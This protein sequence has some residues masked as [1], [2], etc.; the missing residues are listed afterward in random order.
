MTRFTGWTILLLFV[1]AAEFSCYGQS[2][3]SMIQDTLGSHDLQIGLSKYRSKKYEVALSYFTKAADKN[4]SNWRA[5]RA[6][7]NAERKVK[8]YERAIESYSRA[9]SINKQDTSSFKGRAEAKRMAG[10]YSE[11]LEDY[12][13]ALQWD[14]ND[15][16]IRFGRASSY[17]SLR[18]YL[19]AISDYTLCIRNEPYEPLFYSKRAIS[20]VP[21]DR[22]D[23]AKRDFKRYFE[24]GGKDESA[25][26]FTGLINVYT[27]D[28]NIPRIDSAISDLIRYT[29]L[30]NEI[31]SKNPWGYQMLA[32]AYAKK[33]D[34]TNARI[35]FRKSLALDSGIVDTYFRWGN[36]ELKFENYRKANELI[37]ETLRREKNPSASVYLNLG[38]ANFGM[39]D[40]IRGIN[41]FQKAL[42]IDSTEKDVYGYRINILFNNIK[43][44]ALVIK[45]LDLLIRKATDVQEKAECHTLKSMVNSQIGDT[46]AA[47]VEIEMAI[48]LMPME[49]LHYLVR[50]LL[51]SN[52]NRPQGEVLRDM[53]KAIS[54]DPSMVDAYTQMAY[55]YASQKD[56]KRGCEVLGQALKLGA[57]FSKIF[58]DYVCFGK[59]PEDGKSHNLFIP[60]QPRLL[61]IDLEFRGKQE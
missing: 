5:F 43:Y 9:L 60:L 26:Y 42:E 32:M 16:D 50:A 8:Q 4:P 46:T 25:Y 17:Y 45:D 38:V 14:P 53:Q 58:R 49:P 28:N 52:A 2:A 12:N 56:Y 13:I 41:N 57:D 36:A 35:N 39:G 6:K 21:L 7:G 33:G 44:S 3:S 1:S 10:F 40:T 37:S 18:E 61:K 20:F 34:S 11:S 55:Y 15:G 27:G 47:R 30:K 51:N 59:L 29:S 19:R 54:L 31:D 48:Q 23:E 24:L 22:F